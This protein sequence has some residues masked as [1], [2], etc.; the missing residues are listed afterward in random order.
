M[1]GETNHKDGGGFQGD[2]NGPELLDVLKFRCVIHLYSVPT[3][4]HHNPSHLWTFDLGNRVLTSSDG[5]LR[6]SSVSV[7]VAQANQVSWKGRFGS[8]HF[9][10]FLSNRLETPARSIGITCLGGIWMGKQGELEF[11]HG[12]CSF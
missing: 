10:L 9:Y 11:K 2:P 7:Y 5:S 4:E 1:D 3:K 8:L 6:S 12:I